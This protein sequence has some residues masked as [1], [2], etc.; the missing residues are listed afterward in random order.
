MAQ[1][2]DFEQYFLELVNRAR[3]DPG[4]EAQRLGLGLNDGLNPG[5]ISGAAKQPPAFN[6]ALIDAARGHGE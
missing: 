2:S 4:A 3:S 1:P 6:A 5:T